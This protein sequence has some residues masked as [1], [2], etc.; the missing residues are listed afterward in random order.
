MRKWSRYLRRV[1]YLTASGARVDLVEEARVVAGAAADQ[2]VGV[3]VSGVDL[4]V[5][6]SAAVGVIALSACYG[7]VPD[8]A[9]E[10]VVAPAA[11]HLVDVLAAVHRVVAREVGGL[12]ES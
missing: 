11:T 5:A 2:G 1:L 8:L 10:E 4:V 7:V 9:A 3:P 12:G 6:G